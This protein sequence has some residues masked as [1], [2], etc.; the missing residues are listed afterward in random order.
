MRDT[1]GIT[2]IALIVTIIVLLI[3]AG[4]TILQLTEN[5]LLDKISQAKEENLKASIKEEII[6]TIYEIQADFIE[7]GNTLN[8]DD[9]S[10]KLLEEKNKNISSYGETDPYSGIYKK[11]DQNI[12]FTIKEDFSIII[13]NEP[14]IDNYDDFKKWISYANLNNNYNTISELF[15]NIED[16]KTVM[17]TKECVDYMILSSQKLMQEIT[18]NENAIREISKSDYAASQI[19]KNDN[20]FKAIQ[21]STYSNVFDENAIKIPALSDN[22]SNGIVTGTSLYSSAFQ[23]YY[24]F[25]QKEPH[26]IS[27]LNIWS[28][29]PYNN[30]WIA[31]QFNIEN[32]INI[33]K[34]Q[35]NAYAE[36][37]N[38]SRRFFP[39]K[40]VLQCK[41]NEKDDN[42]NSNWIDCSP[43]FEISDITEEGELVTT[44]SET[45]RWYQ[46]KNYFRSNIYGKKF[47]FYIYEGSGGNELDINCLQ[48][49][50]R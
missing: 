3:L 50:G 45:N 41:I 36:T 27:G 24:P 6:L 47:R 8:R 38:V 33:Y 39:K 40:Y 23:L 21:N 10:Q 48:I 30:S 28:P 7:N 26:C 49:Y 1:R 25:T 12:K 2:L 31:Y 18:S 44:F 13:G 29:L 9:L 11:G 5:G 37:A 46:M 34:I 35:F 15:Q 4:I 20:W 32:N 43:I 22:T 14:N 42:D 19:I 17:N 16:L